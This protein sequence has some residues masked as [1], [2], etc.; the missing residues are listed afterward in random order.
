MNLKKLL[1]AGVFLILLGGQVAPVRAADEA[2]SKIVVVD[3][4]AYP[5]FAFL[6]PQGNPRGVTIDIWNLWSQRTGIPVE[7][8][9][10]DW[11]AALE[12]VLQ[13]RADAVGGL[14]CAPER[15][16]L[17]DPIN[18]NIETA[19]SIFF[20]EG[21]SG[22][23]GYEDLV[24]FRVGVVQDDSAEEL[25]RSFYPQ[26]HLQTY[27]GA[28]ALVRAA[29]AGEV[30]VFVADVPTAR[31]YLAQTDGGER[32]YQASHS[33]IV[34][35]QSPAVRKGNAEMLRIIQSGFDRISSSEVNAIVQEWEGRSAVSRVPWR[36]LGIGL[37]VLLLLI[38][39]ILLWNVQL[40]R[41]VSLATRDI[42]E[43]NRQLALSHET[44]RRNEVRWKQ[45]FAMAPIPLS[46]VSEQGLEVNETFTQVLGYTPEDISTLDEWWNRAYPD[47]EYRRQVRKTWD[48]ALLRAIES[49]TDVEPQE[50]RVTCKDGSVRTMIINGAEGEGTLLACF[51]DITE[52]KQAEQ[53]LRESEENYRLL[54]DS[55]NSIILRMDPTGKVT[56]FNNFAER[57]LGFSQQEIL[58]KNVVG[59]IVPKH[60]SEGGDQERMILEIGSNPEGYSSNENENMRK[61]GSR[62]WVSWT[63]K[64]ILDKEG[65]IREILCIGNNITEYK[66]AEL[67]LRE[68]E[69]RYAQAISATSDAIWEWYLLTGQAFYTPRWYEMLGYRD[70]EFEMT[71]EAWKDLC[72]PDDCQP[73]LDKIQATLDSPDNRGYEAEFRMRTRSGEWRWIQGRG[74]VVARDA[75]G[76]PIV[77][78]GTN[79][80]ITQRRLAEAERE[81][82]LAAIEQC[83]EIILVT[84][85]LGTIEY[86][87][88]AFKAV[89]GYS[90]EEVIGQTPRILKSG[91]QD[92][93]FYRNLWKT[94]LSGQTWKGRFVNK[95]KD[96]TLYTEEAVISPVRDADGNITNY[97]SAKNDISASL[98]LEA[99]L[100]QAQK[101]ESVGRLAGGVAHDF[102]NM[103]G[104]ILGHAELALD[105]VDPSQAVHADLR[106]ILKA[107]ERS[108]NLTRQ[109]LAFARKQTV[110]PKVLDLNET[111]AS[112][113][114]MLQRLI[115]ENVH[116][117]WL[118]GLNLWPVLMDPSQIDQILA[119]LCVNARDAIA[120]VGHIAI[121]TKNRTIDEEYCDTHVDAIPGEY[122]C[123]AV[124]DSGC[125]MD[126]ETQSH[127]F[128]PFF[129]TK[130]AGQGTGLG[131]ATVYGIV[132]QNNGFIHVYSEPGHGSVFSIYLP[133]HDGAIEK[134]WVENTVGSVLC[135]QE[136]ILLVEDEPAI[137]E[138]CAMM[139]EKL[140]YTVLPANTPSDGARLAREFDGEIHLLM[141]DVVMPEMNGRDLAQNLMTL[142]PRMKCLFMSGY[143]ADVIAHRSVLEAGVHFLPKPF[144]LKELASRVRQ[145][146]DE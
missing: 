59:T 47:P 72:H 77:L 120:D 103:L 112:M 21:I 108:A 56:F 137:I 90:R 63:N 125:G 142:Y 117:D 68:S 80:D 95:R 96:G 15:E 67:A 114:K 22:I 116:L 138:L 134:T 78:G 84:D 32:F 87:N 31:Y 25:I 42:E 94:L 41:E 143:T 61:D 102:N 133:R 24:G 146:L 121:E 89:T 127:L 54:L 106:E 33:Q 39:V 79:T 14:V 3:D 73:T 58:G 34:N 123:L 4:K 10:M 55:A 131:L 128:E 122:V 74:N 23:K 29:A 43:Q 26:V 126:Q 20:Q 49:G 109:L 65:N 45:L 35:K 66:L 101:M 50:Y 91:Q 18:E 71:V 115:G 19:S 2:P 69:R 62:V 144:S 30:K 111:L 86:V 110:A 53:A 113:L 38:G 129:T 99:D 107:T 83:G 27:P 105:Q 82:L 70:R 104:V 6:D 51:F 75:N 92:A 7:F 11:D 44:I 36:E 132:K 13:G 100:R 88:P 136:T 140:G 118:P 57:F 1:L 46:C 9:L 28:D 40:R 93:E 37:T 60:D 98:K 76:K 16:P 12:A 52:R 124:T 8:Q 97:V 135:G 139:L 17:F 119:N 5:P 145:A 85:S 141:T 64:E 48:G 81:R 130:S